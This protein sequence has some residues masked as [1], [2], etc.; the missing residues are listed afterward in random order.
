VITEPEV[1]P[2][3]SRPG[4]QGRQARAPEA[5]RQHLR[6][7]PAR[8]VTFSDELAVEL[9]PEWPSA[10]MACP[11]TWTSDGRYQAPDYCGT[12]RLGRPPVAVM[13][14]AACCNWAIL[15]LENPVVGRQHIGGLPEGRCISVARVLK[16]SAACPSIAAVRAPG[17]GRGAGQDIND[18]AELRDGVGVERSRLLQLVSYLPEPFHRR[19]NDAEQ[20]LDERVLVNGPSPAK[21]RPLLSSSVQKPV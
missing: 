2:M 9:E 14:S 19:G 10:G 1:I 13:T 20:K 3:A 16:T 17:A 6:P 4:A 7:Q 21:A 8:S 18:L 5:A 15:V 11:R 12:Y